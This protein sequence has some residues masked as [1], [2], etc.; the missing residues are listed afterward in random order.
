MS[1]SGRRVSILRPSNRRLSVSK[2]LSENG[3]CV[4]LLISFEFKTINAKNK[5][6]TN[7]PISRFQRNG[8]RLIVNS[9][10]PTRV[11][12]PTPVLTHPV[13]PLVLSGAQNVPPSMGFLMILQVGPT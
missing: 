10:P 4:Q 3:E 8:P 6:R 12:V 1:F 7:V 11:I 5:I 2:G 13:L 9:E